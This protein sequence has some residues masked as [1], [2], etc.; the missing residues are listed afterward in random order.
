MNKAIQ[1]F[2]G[3]IFLSAGLFRIF[4]YPAAQLEVNGLRL[5][6]VASVLVITLELVISICFLAN[7]FVKYASLVAALFLAVP[8]SISFFLYPDILYS[9]LSELFVFN[10]TATD[11]FLHLMFLILVVLIFVTERKKGGGRSP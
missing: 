6:V 3:I 9:Q 7:R 11:V 10:A 1:M 5:P 4:N 8:I 2:L